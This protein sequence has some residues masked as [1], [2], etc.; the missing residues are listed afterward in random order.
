MDLEYDQKYPFMHPLYFLFILIIAL[1][2]KY[3]LL[4]TSPSARLFIKGR[5]LARALVEKEWYTGIIFEG[6]IKKEL[7]TK[8]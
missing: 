2:T 8:V 7:F 5:V 3:C 4:C 1:G 6:S